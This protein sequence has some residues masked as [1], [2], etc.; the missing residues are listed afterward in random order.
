MLGEN[1]HTNASKCD[2]AI[3][4]K[5]VSVG[6]KEDVVEMAGKHLH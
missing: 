4:I 6:W 3:C 2:F 1:S 5:D